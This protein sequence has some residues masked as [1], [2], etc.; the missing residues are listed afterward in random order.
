[1]Y[2]CMYV[3]MLVCTY[4]HSHIKLHIDM[5]LQCIMNQAHRSS[6]MLLNSMVPSRVCLG[7]RFLH[8]LHRRPRL[9][10]PYLHVC[11]TPLA[12]TMQHKRK[13]SSLR[14]WWLYRRSL[15]GFGSLI[16]AGRRSPGRRPRHRGTS[17][18][19]HHTMEFHSFGFLGDLSKIRLL[20]PPSQAQAIPKH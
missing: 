14:V 2:T 18:P 17:E 20:A 5:R 19:W 7:S 15:G 8:Q 11:K 10:G 3:C 4:T 1:M 9:L 13:V 6:W 16:C 12:K